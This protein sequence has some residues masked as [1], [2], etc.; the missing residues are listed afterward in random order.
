MIQS[1][2]VFP[3]LRLR[4]GTEK[5]ILDAKTLGVSI[6]VYKD[7]PAASTSSIHYLEM[8]KVEERK[9]KHVRSFSLE[10]LMYCTGDKRPVRLR[11]LMLHLCNARHP[12]LNMESKR[13]SL[14]YYPS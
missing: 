12:I 14:Q 9:P 1:H 2:K 4:V 8:T 6:K 7:E 10:I 13:S 3:S 11:P 5:M